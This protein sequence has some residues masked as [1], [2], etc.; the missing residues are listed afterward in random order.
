MLPEPQPTIVT[1]TMNPALDKSTQV[2]RVVPEEKLRCDALTAEPGGGGVNVSRVIHALGGRSLLVYLVGG[3]TG[4][5]LAQLLQ[6]EGLHTQPIPIA[7]STRE[8]FTVL[9]EVSLCQYRFN[10]PG[11][12]LAEA[13]WQNALETVAGIAPRPA[14]LVASGSLPPGAPSDFYVRLAACFAG[15][16]TKV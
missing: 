6:A 5:A 3:L 9:E 1:L 4:Q 12:V 7:G 14:Y 15:S 10:M 16:E 2:Q 13:E 8:S 11:P